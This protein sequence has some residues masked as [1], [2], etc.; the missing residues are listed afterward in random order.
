MKRIERFERGRKLN[1]LKKA[2]KLIF[3]LRTTLAAVATPFSI[4]YPKKVGSA[5]RTCPGEII[6]RERER[7]RAREEKKK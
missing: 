5:T 7:E 2:G 3:T 4:K 1:F 6:I